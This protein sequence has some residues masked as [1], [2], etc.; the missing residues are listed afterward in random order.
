MSN[1][2]KKITNG[3]I[4]MCTETGKD[5]S[6]ICS[7][8]PMP[9]LKKSLNGRLETAFLMRLTKKWLFLWLSERNSV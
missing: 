4:E 2:K 9:N 3:C 8:F 6:A 7:T 5:A 1:P